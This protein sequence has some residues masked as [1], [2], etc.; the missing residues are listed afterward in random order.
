MPI[1]EQIIQKGEALFSFFKWLENL[2]SNIKKNKGLL[3]TT[4]SILSV[5]GI[6]VSLYFVSFLVDDVA[7][8][9]FSSEQRK[10]SQEMKL[11]IN[12]E[13]DFV[14]S[15]AVTS[16]LDSELIDI[17]KD[18]N[19][20]AD[21]IEKKYEQISKKFTQELN[22]NL[23]RK[24]ISV[25]FYTEPKSNGDNIIN[26]LVV[27]N[28]GTF[29]QAKM[30]FATKDDT[31]LKVDITSDINYLKDLYKKENKDFIYIVNESST[32]KLDRLVFKTY[33]TKVSNQYI[34]KNTVY[35]K[36]T[37]KK[38]QK[39]DIK[40]LLKDGYTKDR[41]NFYTANKLYDVNGD[42]IGVVILSKKIDDDSIV[43]LVKSLVN[44]VTMV[45]LGLIVS[46]ILF[47]F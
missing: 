13:K 29:F 34:I 7:K 5:V 20:T 2:F 25:K 19:I 28:T 23:S 21:E 35:S 15:V 32:S 27:T 16:K 26:G 43:K 12:K 42:E 10:Y 33:Y 30:P 4:L 45:A 14:L 41:D 3:F 22:K 11:I 39:L 44:N 40:Q 18:Q 6:F 37:I 31:Y 24:D 38:L 17:Y 36:E 47:L 46:M 1:L 9:S 8:K